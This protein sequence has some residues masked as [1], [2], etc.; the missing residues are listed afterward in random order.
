MTEHPVM[1]LLAAGGGALVAVLYLASLRWTVRRIPHARHPALLVI[2]SYLIR[3]PLAAL[4]LVGVASGGD[5]AAFGG[6]EGGARLVATLAGFLIVRAVVLRSERAA[7]LRTHDT[8]AR[9][10]E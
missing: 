1:W 7:V 9:S 5:A 4:A 3:A 2:A 10:A 6:V 8:P